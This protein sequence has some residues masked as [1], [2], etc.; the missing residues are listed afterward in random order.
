MVR[1]YYIDLGLKDV[2][3]GFYDRFVF[4]ADGIPMYPYETGAAYNITFVCHYALYH[5]CL[6]Q[7]FGRAGDLATFLKI[8][9]WVS[10]RGEETHESFVFPY[11]YSWGGMEPPWIS[12]LGQG[13]LLSLF[14]RAHALTGLDRY[15]DI[16]IK[17][18]HPF[19]HAVEDGGLKTR[20]PDGGIAWEEYP[21]DPPNI[22]LNGLI[23]ALVGIVDLAETGASDSATDLFTE[24]LAGLESNLHRYD[25]GYWSAYDLAG[26]RRG[27][28]PEAYHRYHVMQLWALYE[29]TGKDTF[30]DVSRKWDSYGKGIRYHAHLAYSKTVRLLRLVR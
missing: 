20:F 25:L 10:R 13:R 1:H 11:M 17:A 30:R 18:L 8:A 27:P 23:T 24:G 9:D 21:Q 15:I 28:A 2:R 26:R 16:A 19:L 29:M 3:V 5:L 14:T 6:H 7:R 22:V 12:A 4:D